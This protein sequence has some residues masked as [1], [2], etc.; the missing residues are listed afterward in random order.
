MTFRKL[1]Y[2]SCALVIAGFF[3]AGG[4]ASAANPPLPDFSGIWRLNQ[5][6]S[7]DASVI[8]RRLRAERNHEQP[9]MQPAVAT[10]TAAPA[11]SQ[12]SNQHGGHGGGMGRGGM[13]GGHGGGH[14][15]K[16]SST[17]DNGGTA[18]NDPSP[19]LLDVDA[20]L[21]VQ[22]DARNV[23]VA[24]SDSDRLDARLDGITRQSLNGRA[25][26][27]SQLTAGGLQISMQFD[28]GTRLEQTWLQSPDG[29]HLTVTEQW[30][31][32]GIRQPITFT[33]NYDR[34]DI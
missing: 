30:T 29:H 21:N 9:P 34:L 11:A 14:G 32:P 25:M 12:T 19:P 28:D 24:L 22:Q 15:H 8:T 33:R 18:P 7:D 20:L 23:Q 26:V 5:L 17:S 27:Q 13:G 16:S 4:V 2:L 1:L 10:S 31:T 3:V 6:H